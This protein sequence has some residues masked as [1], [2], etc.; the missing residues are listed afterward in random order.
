MQLDPE[1]GAVAKTIDADMKGAGGSIKVGQGSIWVRGTLTLLKQIDS[2]TGEVLA[3]YGP[4][5]G[6][7]DSLIRDGVLWISAFK[8][9]HGTGPGSGVV[10]RLPLSK[11]G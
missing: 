7:G 9:G 4:D 11:L 1:T 5:Q 2:A 8:P 6:S 3:Q 10:Y